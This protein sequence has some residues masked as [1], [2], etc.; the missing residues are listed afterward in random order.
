V[1]RY[2]AG[3]VDWLS[4]G[5]PSEGAEA[6]ELRI[7]A[8]ARRQVATCHLGQRVGEIATEDGLCVVVNEAGIVLGDLRGKA[9]KADPRTPVEQV[10]NPGPSTYRPN[11]SVKRMAHHLLESGA[12]RVLV[13]DGDGR[14]IGW[15]TREDVERALDE[16]RHA[17]VAAE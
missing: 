4:N 15:L 7:G 8:I 5:L 12:R 1:Y 13:T 3:K 10:M 11:L 17:E 6:S 16:H 9:L 14:L 2:A